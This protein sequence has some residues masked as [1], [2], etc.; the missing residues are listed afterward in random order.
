[1]VVSIKELGTYSK[2]H[3]PRL[4]D[5]IKMEKKKNKKYNKQI[6][7]LSVKLPANSQ[8]HLQ[9]DILKDR[10]L[11]L[12]IHLFR[13]YCFNV[14]NTVETLLSIVDGSQ[15]IHSST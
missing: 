8:V 15:N 3:H 7:A 9:S 2:N 6:Y 5:M 13:G 4:I 10:S 14:F 12:F 1:M 11:I